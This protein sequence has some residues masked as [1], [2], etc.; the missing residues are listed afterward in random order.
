MKRERKCLA[1][2]LAAALISAALPVPANAAQEEAEPVV[3]ASHFRASYY[4]DY[5]TYGD[6]ENLCYYYDREGNCVREESRNPE[7]TGEYTLYEDGTRKS[8]RY[9][10]ENELVRIVEF[11][12]QGNPRK[13]TTRNASGE[14]A[15]SKEYTNCY[16]DMGRLL[17]HSEYDLIN[18]DA[19]IDRYT[20]HEDGGYT[21]ERTMAEQMPDGVRIDRFR[22]RYRYDAQGRLL[23]E[24][25]DL[26]YGMPMERQILY[27][28]DSRGGLE[29]REIRFRYSE[30]APLEI[31]TY[32]YRNTYNS[33]GQL[34][35]SV[36]RYAARIGQKDDTVTQGT[37][38]YRYDSAGRMI[39]KEVLGEMGNRLQLQTWEYDRWDHLLKHT[40]DGEIFEENIYVPLS[41]AL[42][43]E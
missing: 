26:D 37:T 25:Q 28:Y 34:A 40:R 39:R 5:L 32:T 30:D 4:E 35:R 1:A 22:F 11:D 19:D 16:D 24:T 41:Q 33:R 21:H 42:W 29:E 3:L 36:C 9:Y 43:R 23:E 13:E 20:Y 10:Q 18:L 17:I 7:Y 12:C 2:V 38:L 8:C 31:Y 6:E 27:T 15:V 14:M